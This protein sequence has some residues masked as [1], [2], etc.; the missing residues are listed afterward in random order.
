MV[1]RW[2]ITTIALAT[3]FVLVS[4][5]WAIP[6]TFGPAD[7]TVTYTDFISILL[8]AIAVLMTTLAIFLAVLGFMGWAS[9]E[10]K[11]EQRT[12]RYL[13][14]HIDEITQKAQ[15]EAAKRVSKMFM[16]VESIDDISNGYIED[17]SFGKEK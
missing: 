4:I 9:I 16:G 2:A 15:D 12:K 5:G 11:V 3:A 7:Y 14:D 1:P 13:D 6:R 10:Q 17:N 8:T